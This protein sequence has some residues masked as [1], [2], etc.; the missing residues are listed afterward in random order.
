MRRKTRL[1]RQRS[2]T[3][4]RI[5]QVELP[6]AVIDLMSRLQCLGKH[7]PGPVEITSDQMRGAEV[8]EHHSEAVEIIDLPGEAY[9]HGTGGPD[10]VHVAV[11]EAVE[12]PPLHDRDRRRV[13]PSDSRA[14]SLFHRPP[15]G[16]AIAGQ[17]LAE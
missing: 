7:W 8:E 13:V 10:R 6:D 9:S 1:P 4:K 2:I 12:C 11:E 3:A 15:G 14:F 17:V 5:Q 16:F